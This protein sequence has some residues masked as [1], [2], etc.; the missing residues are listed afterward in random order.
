MQFKPYKIGAQT[1]RGF[2]FQVSEEDPVL[3]AKKA[4]WEYLPGV[5]R[6][7]GCQ[8]EG[9]QVEFIREGDPPLRGT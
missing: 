2:H 3:K 8:I 5:N 4:F 9:G 7:K 6:T 1:S